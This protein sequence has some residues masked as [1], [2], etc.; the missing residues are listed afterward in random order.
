MLITGAARNG[1]ISQPARSRNCRVIRGPVSIAPCERAVAACPV[2]VRSPNCCSRKRGVR[3][4]AY[5]KPLSIRQILKW[6]DAHF[7][8]TGKWPTKQL[9]A[10]PEAPGETWQA[11]DNALYLGLRDLRHHTLA[12]LLHR[13]R[14]ARH[15]LLRPR[16]TVKQILRWADAHFATTGQWPTHVSGA[17]LA[18]PDEDWN[19]IQSA[20]QRGY[21]GLPGGSSLYQVLRKHRGVNRSVRAVTRA[22]PDESGER[23]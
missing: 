12:Q 9:G 4:S 1:Q 8:R 19:S 3:N 20:L 10:I 14:G 6:A 18:A 21:H 17:V 23:L 7:R 13:H 22:V 16:L 2:A 15:R 11:I 5:L